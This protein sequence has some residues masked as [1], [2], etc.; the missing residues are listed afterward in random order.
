MTKFAVF[1]GSEIL[2]ALEAM[3]PERFAGFKPNGTTYLRVLDAKKGAY[4]VHQKDR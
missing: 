1:T 3:Y 4:E 2:R